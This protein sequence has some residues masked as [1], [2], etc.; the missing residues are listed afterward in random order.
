MIN[1]TPEEEE[2]YSDLATKHAHF[3]CDKVFKPAFEMAFIHG[4][5]HMKEDM[6]SGAC[7]AVKKQMADLMR[8]NPIIY[9]DPAPG[10]PIQTSVPEPIAGRK[11]P[12]IIEKQHPN[13]STDDA[14]RFAAAKAERI[15]NGE[16]E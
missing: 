9:K 15:A 4:A 13:V 1:L 11:E 5:K 8:S 12:E 10:D 6:M 2:R 3:L 14:I 7:D 16:Q